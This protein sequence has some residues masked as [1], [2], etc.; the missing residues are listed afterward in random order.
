MLLVA[1]ALSCDDK[2]DDDRVPDTPAQTQEAKADP[3]GE[4][5]E[6]EAKVEPKPPEPEAKVEPKVKTPPEL[7]G[8]SIVLPDKPSFPKSTAPER[9]DDGAWSVAGL[10]ENLEDN[11]AKGD[12]GEEIELRATV[13][14][15]YVPPPCP[16]DGACPPAKQPH[17]WVVDDPADKGKR[18]A[19]MVVNYAFV[20]PEWDAKRWKGEPMVILEVGREYTFKG[21]FRQ[22]S[23]TGFA[24]DRGLLEFVAVR[25]KGPDGKPTWIY[26]PGAPWH[27]LEVARKG[28]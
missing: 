22:F 10:R 13:L 17:A 12:A 20:I 24:S 27:P 26:P 19:A 3:V 18:R 15:L 7:P 6:P 9:Y 25:D 5:V 16:P 28:G 21:K 23:D 1:L 8:A 11:V 14:E 4:T 2:K